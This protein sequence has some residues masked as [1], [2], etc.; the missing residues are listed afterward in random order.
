MHFLCSIR[1]VRSVLRASCRLWTDHASLGIRAINHSACRSTAYPRMIRPDSGRIIDHQKLEERFASLARTPFTV[2]PAGDRVTVAVS[3]WCSRKPES[4]ICRPIRDHA[5]RRIYKK[6]D[7]RPLGKGQLKSQSVRWLGSAL[8]GGRAH[9][10]APDPD[11]LNGLLPKSS[12]FHVGPLTDRV[13]ATNP[14]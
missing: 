13:A 12:R 9:P 5:V 1:L 6:V 14:D 4:G 7:L 11:P 3:V 2:A 8:P 10:P